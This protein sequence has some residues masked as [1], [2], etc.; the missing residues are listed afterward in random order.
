[1]MLLSQ[2][3]CSVTSLLD[4]YFNLCNKEMMI[5]CITQELWGLASVR[6]ALWDHWMRVSKGQRKRTFARMA[7]A[8]LKVFS[9]PGRYTS[10]RESR[11]YVSFTERIGHCSYL[12]VSGMQDQTGIVLFQSPSKTRMRSCAQQR[13]NGPVH[14]V[15]HESPMLC[16]ERCLLTNDFI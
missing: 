1:M 8:R 9:V 4:R 6:K 14:G 15:R 2:T 3:P 12:A 13:K 16:C 11:T 7:S 5:H 10:E